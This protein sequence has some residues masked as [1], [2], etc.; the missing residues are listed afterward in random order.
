MKKRQSGFR[1]TERAHRWLG[2]QSKER[3]ISKSDVIQEW[4]NGEIAKEA[5]RLN[6]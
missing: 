6:G 5:G 1:F 2:E 4:I 3:G